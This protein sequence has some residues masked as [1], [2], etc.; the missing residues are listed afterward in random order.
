MDEN[1]EEKNATVSS[2]DAQ[3][4]EE[5]KQEK[6]VTVDELL[7]NGKRY[8]AC[9]ENQEAADCFEE[10]CG[11][12]AEIH[13]QTGKELAEPYF[14]YGKALLE[15]GRQESGVLGAGVPTEADDDDDSEGGSE[16]EE[17]PEKKG[18][19][20]TRPGETKN[21]SPSKKEQTDEHM[22]TEDQGDQKQED[23]C[24][25]TSKEQGSSPKDQETDQAGT[26]GIVDAPED[27][28]VKEGEAGLDDT[29]DVPTMQVA[30]EV[31]ELARI[32]HEKDGQ[33]KNALKLAEIHILL[34]EINMESD[35][36][37]EAAEDF[38][39][40]LR[41]RTDHLTEDDRSIAECHFQLGM[42]YTLSKS[43]DQAVEA[44]EFA[45]SVLKKKLESLRT[46]QSTSDTDANE[47]KE[48]E[49]ILPDIDVKIEDVLEMKKLALDHKM[50]GGDEG[51]TTSGFDSPKLDA[52]VEPTKISFR[53]VQ[54]KSSVTGSKRT[55]KG[56]TG[57]ELLEESDA[58]R[59]KPSN[60]EADQQENEMA[61]ETTSEQ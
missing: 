45:K 53:K 9:G 10:A 36:Q 4:N 16:D 44:Y 41:I 30:W 48:L 27:P 25:P 6:T 31:L 57:S 59:L 54:P 47:I 55:S 61:S 38:R 37:E 14:L 19:P 11:Q 5:S 2:L 52:T 8:L 15:V 42:V 35:N 39:K 29:A 56:E 7:S 17:E 51:E 49:G 23:S 21:A 40:A 58:K 3:E 1:S 34:G 20:S 43:F 46:S 22:E 33:D 18:E 26:S 32:I 50:R 28:T 24:V 60:G 13:G 12:L